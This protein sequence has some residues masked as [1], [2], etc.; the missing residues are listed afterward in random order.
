MLE[1]RAGLAE[2][3]ERSIA[4][5]RGWTGNMGGESVAL[6]RAVADCVSALDALRIASHSN[7]WG[8][9]K[10]GEGGATVVCAGGWEEGIP[11]KFDNATTCLTRFS[12][13]PTRSRRAAFSI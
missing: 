1:G 8:G 9:T 13:N 12:S 2:G 3:I 4:V 7:D 5:S 11:P 10:A 6:N